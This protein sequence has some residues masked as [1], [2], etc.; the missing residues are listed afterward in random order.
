VS[1]AYLWIPGQKI[2]PRITLTIIYPL[3]IPYI[4]LNAQFEPLYQ[5]FR[6]LGFPH[7]V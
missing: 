1:T 7:L 5:V 2:G 4:S 3:Y 6:Q